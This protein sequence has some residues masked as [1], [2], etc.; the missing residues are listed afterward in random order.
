[1][2][3]TVTLAATLSLLGPRVRPR[4]RR[5]AVASSS[6]TGEL[7][8]LLQM[9][10]LKNVPM[11]AAL[12][13]FG[14]YGA[15][16][17]PPRP[18]T[19]VASQLVLG[20]ATTTIVTT[21]SMLI[22]DY[23]DWRGGVDTAETKPGRPLVTGEVRPETVKLVLKWGYALHLTL[24]C[25]VEPAAL[26]LLVLANTLLTYLYSVRLKPVTGVKNAVCAGI[27][28]MALGLGAVARAAGDGLHPLRAVWRPLAAVAGLIWHR[29]VLMDIEDV[30]GDS[31]AGVR[32]LPVALG[33]GA[34]ARL[35][36]APLLAAAAAAASA[37]G[38]RG[39]LASSSLLLTGALAVRAQLGGFAPALLTQAIEL[40]PFLLLVA[41]SALTSA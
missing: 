15:R 17:A 1:M 24:L 22:N 39:A 34:A 5:A 21:G 11:G 7:R 19:M 18:P 20:V 8:G 3:V 31:A 23:H 9:A 26:R 38:A 12:V 4:R 33:V 27:I 35:A 40:S 36:L 37:G 41:L 32:T 10:R 28:S 14:A 2:A 6:A 29:E 13:A 16:H 25:L 30:E